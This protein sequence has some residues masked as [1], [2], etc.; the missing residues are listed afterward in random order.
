VKLRGGD[1]ICSYGGSEGSYASDGG[2]GAAGTSLSSSSSSTS[3]ASYTCGCTTI[4]SNKGVSMPENPLPI[5]LIFAKTFCIG[6][7]DE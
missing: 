2:K 3:A 6:A 7:G 4:V 1:G 5:L